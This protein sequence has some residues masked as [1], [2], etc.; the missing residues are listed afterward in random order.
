MDRAADTQ[1]VDL[2]A[3]FSHRRMATLQGGL[4]SRNSLLRDEVIRIIKE[5]RI[6]DELKA[7]SEMDSKSKMTVEAVQAVTEDRWIDDEL[8]ALPE[9]DNDLT[10]EELLGKIFRCTKA[11]S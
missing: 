4:T 6:P 1:L 5:N 9:D 10:D 11:R 7:E 8:Q 3:S 2:P